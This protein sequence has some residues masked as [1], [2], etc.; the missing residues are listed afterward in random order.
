M[1]LPVSILL[2]FAFLNG[3][4]QNESAL[5][6]IDL[7][8]S[9]ANYDEAS[10][11]IQSELS[12]T[13]DILKTSLL[14]NIKAEVL[15]MKGDLQSA[16]ETLSQLKSQDAFTEAVRL[17]NLGFLN[18]NKGRYD[19]ALENLKASEAKFNSSNNQNTKESARCL[20][21]LA[22]VYN[23]TGKYNQAEEY[24]IIA[25]QIRQKL[26]GETSE[27]VA[28]SYND[29]G[30]IYT[31][32]DLDKALESYEK[33]LEI[34][35]KLHGNE[36]PKIAI[37]ATN[38]GINYRQL[39][40]Y[41][42]AIN[43]FESAKKIWEKIY[44]NGH[45][46]QAIVL[47][48]LA[49]TYTQ[50]RDEKATLGYFSKALEVYKKAYGEKHPDI[51]STYNELGI[52]DLNNQKYED[53]LKSFQRALCANAPSFNELDY[54]RNPIGNNFYNPQVM[55]YSLYKKAL[56]LEARYF[57]KSLK[58]EDLKLALNSIYS[59]DSIID[60]LRH[61]SADEDDKLALGE[62]ANGV[63]ED[64]TRMAFSISEVT[65]DSKIYLEKAFYFSEKSKSAVLQESIADAQAKSF[66]GIPSELIEQ[67]K[68]L[69]SN[70]ALYTQ[71]LSQKPNSEEEKKIRE[72]LF[73][74][75]GEYDLFVKKL[76]TSY[77]N[78]YNLK[79][80]KT[81]TTVKDLQSALDTKTALVSYFV[82]ENSKSIYVFTITKKRFQASNFTL[83]DN[84]DRT[85]KGFTNSILYSD[86]PTYKKSAII[87]SK[88]LVP[89]LPSE[90]KELVIIPSGRLGTL[91]FEALPTKKFKDE[92]FNT[93]P[94][95]VYRYGV[96]YEFS[97]SLFYQK[98]KIKSTI[99]MPS[100]FLCAPVTFDNKNNLNELPGTEK[101]VATIA[102]LF[103][104]NSKLVKFAD[105]NETMIKSKELGNYNYLHFATHGIVD[106]ASPESSRIFLSA[107]A[108]EDGNLYAGEI[109]NLNLNANL[110]V[111][112]ACQTGLGKI[113]KGEGVIGLSRAL[114]YAGAK[115]IIV[116]FWS[117]A[118]ESTAELMTNF[119]QTLMKENHEDF[120]KSLQQAKLK[121]ISEG[122]YAAPFYWAPF[123]LIGN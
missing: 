57:G 113:S 68:N 36:H 48:N 119:Y 39:K 18:L 56:A 64:G 77:P 120:K 94:Y 53:A 82:A 61:H 70:I 26:F 38:I 50:M 101:E 62:L 106:E 10:R 85:L 9:N 123:I 121:L 83:P 76:E 117:V 78:Y 15:I 66:S 41:G 104:G 65:F 23:T 87:L 75:N 100:I 84:F 74:S 6:K 96:G 115:N 92:N 103:P 107:S 97:A 42:D 25:L 30:L 108:T 88:L 58:L 112:S 49:L 73:A 59:C 33:A 32:T 86:L 22:L 95:L 24:E 44:P 81:E 37:A 93:I 28:A 4:A 111:L 54:K 43:N 40:L 19:L 105:A 31:G 35:Q 7:L 2:I 1:H 60:D 72:L 99:T 71:K 12:G 122:N 13:T 34:Y 69:K 27:E 109:Y 67:E 91:P 80:S 11:L 52:F 55:I 45:P 63:Y 3:N 47:R 114:I 14:Q 98:S 116:S 29:L 17:S 89:K 8:I 118:D 20:A 51:S 102:N 90:I 46:N 5:K 79:F 16:E 21:N 110:A